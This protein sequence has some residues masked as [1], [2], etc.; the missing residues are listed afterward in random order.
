[1][2]MSQAAVRACDKQCHVSGLVPAV[3]NWR[4]RLISHVRR[5]A[6]LFSQIPNND[7]VPN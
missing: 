6:Y 4:L 1:M 3:D 2:S 7:C 5:Q